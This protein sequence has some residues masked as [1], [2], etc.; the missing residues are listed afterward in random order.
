M[1]SLGA[2]SVIAGKNT[3]GLLLVYGFFVVY[4]S[5][6][7]FEINQL[8]FDAARSGF[9]SIPW[10]DLGPQSRA[11]WIAN[12]LLYIPF[13]FMFCAQI[14]AKHDAVFLRLIKTTIVLA[15]SLAL[16]VSI[17]FFQQFFPPRTV[18]LND[19][20]AETIGTITGIIIWL[21][22]GW[23]MVG[24]WQRGRQNRD[25]LDGFLVYYLIV[26]L[27]HA[28]FPFDFVTSFAELDKN[29]SLKKIEWLGL[30][31][32]GG[33]FYFGW[34]LIQ[35]I[36]TFPIGF[37]FFG[38]FK[39]HYLSSRWIIW[40]GFSFGFLIELLQILLVTG[41]FSGVSVLTR[42]FGL[43]AGF[44][45]F[46]N[47]IDLSWLLVYLRLYI[48][49]FV[50]PYLLILAFFNGWRIDEGIISLDQVS[51]KFA[52]IKW[53]PFY[54]H[55]YQPETTA[56]TSLLYVVIMYLPIGVGV[57]LSRQHMFWSIKVAAVLAFFLATIIESGKLFFSI[58]HPDPTNVIIG[59]AAGWLGFYL[60]NYF[61]GD[62]LS[63]SWPKQF[64]FQQKEP[65][66]REFSQEVKP[67][68]G[69][70]KSYPNEKVGWGAQGLALLLIGFSGWQILEYPV[71]PRIL[72]FGLSIYVILLWKFPRIWLL[73]IPAL[74]LIL[75]FSVLSGRL[76][77]CEFDYLVLLTA[78]VGL[79]TGRWRVSG[80]R[81]AHFGGFFYLIL[82]LLLISYSISLLQGMLPL[83]VLD[84]NAFANYYSRYNALRIIKGFCWAVILLPMFAAEMDIRK[85]KTYFSSGM[86]IGLIGVILVSVWERIVFSGLSNYD[87][88]YR[89]TASFSSMHT[90]GGHIDEYLM[91]A[92][93]FILVLLT[94]ERLNIYKIALAMVIFAFSIYVI[95][96][97]F[98]RGPYIG[99]LIEVMVFIVSLVFKFKHIKG[100]YWGRILY[101]PV[102]LLLVSLVAV[103]VFQGKYIQE[104]FNRVG[105]DYDVRKNHWRDAI[106]MMDD[107]FA[108][109]FLGM[110]LGSYPR[111]YY[112]RN[113][114]KT[115]PATYQFQTGHDGQFLKLWSGDSLYFEQKLAVNPDAQ[116]KLRIDF[117]SSSAK[118]ALTV[119]ICEKALLYSFRCI[120]QTFQLPATDDDGKWQRVES[121]IDTKT[122]SVK[123]SVMSE[124]FRRPVK[125]SLYNGVG[126]TVIDIKSVQLIDS[127][128][129]DIVQ[130]GDFANAMDHWFFSTDNH[131]PWHIKNIWVQVLFEQGWF[132]LIVFCCFLVY[133]VAL[134]SKGLANNDVYAVI[135]LISLFGF[136]VVG[137][138]DSPF[139]EPR[140]TFVFFM[141]CFAFLS[142]QSDTIGPSSLKKPVL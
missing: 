9:K 57:Y 107:D 8:S 37:F 141:L 28:L 127:E 11:D 17:E 138:V 115:V 55:Y 114:E 19:L 119:P 43:V 85:A 4:G 81:Y 137:F 79:F 100:R 21:A 16:A 67:H 102:T 44:R 14:Q 108:T 120:W 103:P 31:S 26:Y 64:H 39:K 12:I 106:D 72:F 99:L 112:W 109:D 118:S 88:D 132:G 60:M 50:F 124:L 82:F 87:S 78:A 136:L 90:G 89:I 18:S 105:E 140:L 128:G 23:R 84:D 122:F 94:G 10:L 24:L 62:A 133:C 2:A 33:I 96:V 58:K 29:I 116:Y 5:L 61:L 27:L 22:Y 25:S 76:F 48:W 30:D 54:Y 139:D 98:S 34:I 45:L 110:G 15:A 46:E 51:Q 95:M 1:N 13:A 86:L 70:T 69:P 129:N 142:G 59:A 20:L 134:F 101:L 131:L 113:S 135:G 53:A 73:V 68:A 65:L 123:D 74:A 121:V 92:V 97:T 77:F 49:T 126:N 41:Y 125:L 36:L 80:L 47:K 111:T 7:P 117:K 63:D 35:I 42:C 91:L 52:Y 3:F 71:F 56:L 130:N 75:D 83:P 6:V 104:R 40:F 66:S 32:K 38:W 93:P